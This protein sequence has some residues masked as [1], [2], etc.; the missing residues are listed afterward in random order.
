MAGYEK[1]VDAVSGTATTGHEWD[2]IKEL[3]TPMPRWWLGLFYLCIVW[4]IGYWIVM[5]AWPG[6]AG[7]THGLLNHSQRDAVTAAVRELQDARKD[8]DRAL[9]HASL[10]QIQSDPD[11]QRPVPEGSPDLLRALPRLV[12]HKPLASPLVTT[13][14]ASPGTPT[15]GGG[16]RR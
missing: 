16:A 10:K 14:R 15:P 6:I 11:L 9:S 8:K 3:D 1:E 12:R 7:Y 4:A 2:G 5:P 13:A